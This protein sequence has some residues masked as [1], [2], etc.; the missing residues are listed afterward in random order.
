MRDAEES[1][2]AGLHETDTVGIVSLLSGELYAVVETGET[3]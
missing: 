2:I 1:D 3:L